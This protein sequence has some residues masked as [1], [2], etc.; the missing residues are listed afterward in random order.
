M[1]TVGVDLFTTGTIGGASFN[2]ARAFD[3]VCVS[4]RT[5]FELLLGSG[6]EG[7]ALSFSFPEATDSENV[8]GLGGRDAG[9]GMEGLG[10]DAMAG[11]P[12]SDT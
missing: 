2:S 12:R 4:R 6:F 11:L 3:E 5:P 9:R 7:S 10:M 1:E 8:I